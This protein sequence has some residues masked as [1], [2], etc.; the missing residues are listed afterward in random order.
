MLDR[1]AHRTDKVNGVSCLKKSCRK[2]FM[3]FAA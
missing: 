1:D 3:P 2:M